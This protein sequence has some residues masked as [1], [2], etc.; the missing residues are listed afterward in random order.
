LSASVGTCRRR[1]TNMSR[2]I[3]WSIDH[4]SI[5]C[6]DQISEELIRVAILWHE[7]WHEGL[8]E[9]SRLY[10][11]ERNIKG[12]FAVLEPL[13]QMMEAGPQTLKETAFSQVLRTTVSICIR[14]SCLW[15]KNVVWFIEQFGYDEDSICW[16]V[17]VFNLCPLNY[18]VMFLLMWMSCVV[19]RARLGRG[20]GM[21][22]Q[23]SS[24]AQRERSHSGV[25]SVLS[26][27]QTNHKTAASGE[28]G[29]HVSFHPDSYL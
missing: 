15:W 8:E 21:V 13:H 16:A 22:S 9:A 23:V 7:L 4:R 19:V 10:F 2:L 25:G 17:I 29:Q 20:A 3:D 5:D 12:M 6:V 14:T 26:R 18:V 28:L 1:Y 27:L 11:G 24:V